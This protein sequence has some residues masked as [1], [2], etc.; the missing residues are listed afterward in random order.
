M[1]A[2]EQALH[3]ALA[4]AAMRE[5]FD[6]QELAAALPAQEHAA[7]LQ[8]L[9]QGSTEVEIEGN[10]FWSLNPAERQ[11]A[12]GRLSRDELKEVLRGTAAL[13]PLGLGFAAVLGLRDSAE[14][15][16]AQRY[17]A[18]ELLRE[19][20]VDADVAGFEQVSRELRGEIARQGAQATLHSTLRTPLR[21]RREVLR[22]LRE[23]AGDGARAIERQGFLPGATLHR[24]SLAQRRWPLVPALLLSGIGGVGKSALIAEL[25]R[26]ERG[27]RWDGRVVVHLDFDEPALKAGAQGA[28]TLHLSRQLALA[29]PVLDAPLAASRARLRDRLL[30]I[31]R[32]PSGAYELLKFALHVE[33]SAW[34]PLLRQE[35]VREVLFVLDTLE[36]VT[37]IG[38]PRLQ[39]LFDWLDTVREAALDRVAVV[40]SG[41]ALVPDG[42]RQLLWPYF[43][44]ELDLGDISR[45]SARD[46]LRDR[47]AREGASRH[48]DSAWRCVE[49]FGSNPLVLCILARYCADKDEAALQELLADAQSAQRK[50][51]VGEIAQKFLYSRILERVRDEDIRPLANPGLV[52]RR[53]TPELI[54]DVLAVPCGLGAISEEKARELLEK[55]QK[56]VWLV[57]PDGDGVRHRPDVR[58]AM[59]PLI[60]ESDKARAEAVAA[61]AEHWYLDRSVSSSASDPDRLE[62]WYYAGLRDRLPTSIRRQELNQLADHLGEHVEDFP[63]STRSRVKSVAGRT[64]SGEEID[65]LPERERAYIEL[66]RNRVLAAEGLEAIVHIK[67]PFPQDRLSADDGDSRSGTRA[68]GEE[69]LSPIDSS[70]SGSFFSKVRVLF[71]TGEFEQVADRFPMLLDR[72]RLQEENYPG[73][74]RSR[75]VDE[76]VYLAALCVRFV[77]ADAGASW[78]RFFALTRLLS[79]AS[80]GFE[81]LL[82]VVFFVLGKKDGVLDLNISPDTPTVSEEEW[83]GWQHAIV[84]LASQRGLSVRLCLA[85][86]PFMRLNLLG[87]FEES[88]NS[89]VGWNSIIFDWGIDVDL[90]LALNRTSDSRD[91]LLLAAI[92]EL[93]RLARDCYVGVKIRRAG[94]GGPFVGLAPE[95]YAPIRNAM[96][97][98]LAREKLADLVQGV[99]GMVPGWPVE[100]QSQQFTAAANVGGADLIPQLLTVADYYGRLGDLVRAARHYGK[101]DGPL[102]RMARFYD[103][104]ESIWQ[105]QP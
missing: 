101:P 87:P 49:A 43:L 15:D 76:V 81:R 51:L 61:A 46:L 26:V 60:W 62:G 82:R 10:Y 8:Q 39:E 36:E 80:R 94:S 32:S 83:G 102:D 29:R 33:L 23:F 16:A 47:F 92:D 9:A 59:L 88:G 2:G 68:G 67:G 97:A 1:R 37:V 17:R 13:D 58:R 77:G 12:L 65:A 55:L 57:T 44:A 104:Y 100:L 54:R 41:R 30:E 103:A 86:L 6:A 48:I 96:R 28:M 22:F 66:G 21:G 19:A 7:L 35:G 74:Q 42:Q 40:A 11:A 79:D 90:A 105:F 18:V 20:H 14:V 56:L 25:V 3:R 98:E 63:L 50:G 71:A 24:A 27:E 69:N 78:R 84:G 34:A 75:L 85:T 64:L 4:Q 91:P 89:S 5:H 72:M 53:V 73:S 95:L 38:L 99:F 93:A 31:E 70:D 45:R 52:L